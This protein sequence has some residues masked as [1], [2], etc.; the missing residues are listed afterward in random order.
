PAVW[1]PRAQAD[2]YKYATEVQRVLATCPDLQIVHGEVAEI[3]VDH[4]SRIT[5]VTLADGTVLPC[6]AVVVGSG[7]FL[8]GLMHTGERKTEGGRVDEGAATGLSGCLARLGLEL[9][10][11]KTGTPPRLKKQTIDFS[12]FEEQPGDEVPAPFSYL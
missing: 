3:D 11:L 1:G 8:R 4:E 9:G 6:R 10:R 5:G 7:T 2:K 12:K